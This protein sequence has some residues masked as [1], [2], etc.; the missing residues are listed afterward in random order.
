MRG[1]LSPKDLIRRYPEIDFLVAEGNVSSQ[2]MISIHK[3]FYQFAAE[4][5]AGGTV[6]DAGCGTGFG[7]DLVAHN[8]DHAVGIDIKDKL[9]SFAKDTY[10]KSNLHFAVMEAG[11]LGF[12]PDTFDVV[13][14]DELLEHLPDHIPFLHETVKVLKPGGKFICA[15]VNRTHSFGSAEAPLNR[16]HFREFNAV[17]FKKELEKYF[18]TVSLS[19][20]RAGGEFQQYMHTRSAR[21]IEWFLLVLNIKH[22]FPPAWRSKVR[23]I[24]TG[25]KADSVPPEKFRVT[26]D[27][28]DSSLYLV[29][30]AHKGGT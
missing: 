11:A 28:V 21:L 9:L 1:R 22:K 12:P 27:D 8:A 4:Q 29:A 30:V 14:A 16:N 5:T 20:Q 17:E 19:G 3:A 23:S 10:I 15:T 6:L 24:L 7:T 18:H 2:Y 13:I 26:Q 25:V